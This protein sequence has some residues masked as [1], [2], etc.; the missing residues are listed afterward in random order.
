ML[1]IG[2]AAGVAAALCVKNGIEP[3]DLN[4]KDLQRI[5]VEWR[6]PLGD[7]ARIAELGLD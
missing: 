6:C 2:Q 1:L 5:L 7:E 4:V 3:R